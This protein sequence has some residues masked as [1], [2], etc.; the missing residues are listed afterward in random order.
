MVEYYKI[1]DLA[2]EIGKHASTVDSWFRKLEE[3]KLHYVN[4]AD[5]ER[6]YDDLDL[7]IARFVKEKREDNWSMDAIFKELEG[8]F[9]LRPFPTHGG[10]V[11][12]EEIREELRRELQEE[13]REQRVQDL[14]LRRKIEA[15]LEEESLRHWDGLPETNRFR[16]GRFFMKQEDLEKREEFVKRYVDRRFEEKFREMIKDRETVQKS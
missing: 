15:E 5:E 12:V 9:D 6:I 10:E 4:R 1:S 11:D 8:E 14:V 7:D 2:K 16:K 3:R 13:M